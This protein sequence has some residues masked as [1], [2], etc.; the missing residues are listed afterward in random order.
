[1]DDECT[2]RFGKL[3]VHCENNVTQEPT[4]RSQDFF[5]EEKFISRSQK[6]SRENTNFK[7]ALVNKL[8]SLATFIDVQTRYESPMFLRNFEL[9]VLMNSV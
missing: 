1:M 8:L 4:I 5:R 7:N 9:N 2:K 6:R 3:R